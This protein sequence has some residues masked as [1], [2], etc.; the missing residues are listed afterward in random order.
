MAAAKQEAARRTLYSMFF[1]GP[2]LGTDIV[3]EM[4]KVTVDESVTV[5]ADAVKVEVVVDENG[6]TRKLSPGNEKDGAP[7]K[8]TSKSKKS[9]LKG[10]EV[11]TSREDVDVEV[12]GVRANARNEKKDKK[13][14][15]D[16]EE[17]DCN[18][19]KLDKVERKRLKA[20]KRARK[21]EKRKLKETKAAV[22]HDAKEMGAQPRSTPLPVEAEVSTRKRKKKD[23]REKSKKKRKSESS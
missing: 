7:Q 10:K 22:A 8:R 13:R 5:Q 16:E 15:R 4:A 2:V 23:D 19:V 11:A 18:S 21:E 14:K 6:G 1:R 12:P 20:E 17:E 9:N 3:E